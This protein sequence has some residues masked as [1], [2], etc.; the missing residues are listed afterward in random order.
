M[1]ASADSAHEASVR[2]AYFQMAS[3]NTKLFIQF[4]VATED[5]LAYR[6]RPRPRQARRPLRGIFVLT[7]CMQ[8]GA[9]Y[10]S[11]LMFARGFCGVVELRA[12]FSP[13]VLF[14]SIPEGVTVT[15]HH[16]NLLF[17][18]DLNVGE[19][20]IMYLKGG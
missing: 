10:G 9:R 19:T 11:L 3:V 8:R 15:A 1:H 7:E 17:K 5:G 16:C 14:G 13:V 20:R 12:R 18:Q 2:R 4:V 6:A